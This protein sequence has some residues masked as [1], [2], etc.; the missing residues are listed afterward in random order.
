MALRI[1][2]DESITSWRKIDPTEGARVFAQLRSDITSAGI[3]DRD[4]LHYFLVSTFDWAGFFFFLS[5]FIVQN[6]PLILILCGFGVSF[7]TVR[8]G[9]LIHDAGHRAIFKSNLL[10]DIYGFA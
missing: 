4:Y 8:L 10:N 2:N 1:R 9:G 5:Q 6:N 3:L 7:F